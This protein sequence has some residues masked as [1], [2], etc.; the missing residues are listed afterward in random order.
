MH[1][2]VQ[3][4]RL[5]VGEPHDVGDPVLGHLGKDHLGTE[6]ALRG[7]RHDRRH[8]AAAGSRGEIRASGASIAAALSCR[9]FSRASSPIC[10]SA[11]AL[12]VHSQPNSVP[13]VPHT[14]RS[15]PYRRTAAS[16]ALG[17]NELQSTYTF[18]RRKRA[19]GSSSFGVSSSA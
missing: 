11:S 14:M 19:E 9:I 2:V 4:V 6:L 18:E 1:E 8:H 16:I 13:S 5:A 10:A 15:P 3:E 12:L 17:P 7:L